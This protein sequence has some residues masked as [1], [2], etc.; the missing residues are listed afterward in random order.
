M[1]RFFVPN[2]KT[3]ILHELQAWLF[4]ENLLAQQVKKPNPH[5][6]KALAYAKIIDQ[7]KKIDLIQNWD[8]L[9]HVKGIGVSI[10]GKIDKIFN[11]FIHNKDK[12]V[13]SAPVAIRRN[14]IGTDKA[15]LSPSS[16][17]LKT[18]SLPARQTHYAAASLRGFTA[19][20]SPSLMKQISGEKA[21]L[22]DAKRQRLHH[23]PLA[24][25]SAFGS[26]QELINTL[27]QIHGIGPA[28]VNELIKKYKIQSIS[29]LQHLI[30]SDPKA[31]N[32]KQKIGVI[33]F[34]DIVKPIP[35][36]EMDDHS[37]YLHSL[38]KH[39]TPPLLIT[40]TG[41]YRRQEKESGDIDVLICPKR[42]YKP[43]ESRL[44]TFNDIIEILQQANYIKDTLA[45]GIS[46]Y[47][48]IV[49]LPGYHVHRRLDI[50]FVDSPESYAFS[51]LYFT[52]N[53]EFNI[54]FR[55]EAA[56][57]GYKLNEYSLYY[58]LPPLEA[59][60]TDK[61]DR[62]LADKCEQI[63]YR[64]NLHTPDEKTNKRLES[65]IFNKLGIGY[66]PPNLRTF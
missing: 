14:T 21:F 27:L 26:N 23:A 59:T 44:Q 62:S 29:D 20:A 13:R 50:L 25:D 38:L 8:D 34:N 31:L 15:S 24:Q 18:R 57:R 1:D 17:K 5:I 40:I 12:S 60:A 37:E 63:I 36:K 33:Y 10:R 32:R 28:K 66:I 39:I 16:S 52:G 43:N 35:R 65:V 46:K 19:T 3:A 42:P 41:S 53:R 48:G 64:S 9:K 56:A 58:R 6:F 2:F 4:H 22:Q 55:K 11:S 54:A 45:Y 30:V 61:V 47:M 51:L 49:K 7:I